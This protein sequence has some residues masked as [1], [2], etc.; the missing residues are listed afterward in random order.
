MTEKLA[1]S[2]R[3]ISYGSN[4]LDLAKVF[5]EDQH[6][7]AEMVEHAERFTDDLAQTIQQA[8]EDWIEDRIH[9]RKLLYRPTK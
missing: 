4:V 8:I 3:P 7:N 2:I 9:D 1:G 6:D 5:V